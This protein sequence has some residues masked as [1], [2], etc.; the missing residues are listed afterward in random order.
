MYGKLFQQMFDGTLATTGPWEA[1]VTFQ[2]LVILADRHGIVDLTPEAI[3]RRTTIPLNIIQKGV[4]ALERPD[5]ESR[6][7]DEGGCRI[8]R[9][10]DSRP[11]GWR[12]VNHAKYRAIRS[13]EE[14]REYMRQYQRERRARLAVNQDVNDGKQVNRGLAKLAN[15][16]T[17]DARSRT[18]P[19][20]SLGKENLEHAEFIAA[21]D[22]PAPF[23][24]EARSGARARTAS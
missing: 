1:L 10:S 24:P 9:L 18:K 20:A 3:S 16:S 21:L 12:I 14:R 17:Q 4:A 22:G 7:P 15:S 8:V 6:T 11:W 23:E 5:P 13:Q 2:Q 19:K